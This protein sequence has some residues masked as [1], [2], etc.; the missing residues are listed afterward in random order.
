MRKLTLLLQA[1]LDVHNAASWYEN[2]RLGLGTRFIDE[3]DYVANRIRISPFQF[4]EIHPAVR[5]G[6]LSRF[7]YSVYFSVNEESIEVIAVLHQ[8]RDPD[9]WRD[10]L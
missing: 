7:P 6:L 3:L 5:R 1:Q 8:H 9:T 4:P 10:R 2:Q